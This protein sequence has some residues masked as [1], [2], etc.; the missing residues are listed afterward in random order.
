MLRSRA[1][2]VFAAIFVAV[3]LVGCNAAK[4]PEVNRPETSKAGSPAVEAPEGGNVVAEIGKEKITLDDINEMIRAIPEQYQPVAQANKGLFLDS[5]INQKLFYAEASKLNFDKDPDVQRQ[6]EE[7][8]K[9]IIIK[10]YLRKE[11]EDT[12]RVSDEDAKKY[13]EANK[14]KFKEPE[15]VNISHILVDNEAEAKDILS[16]LKGGADFA[17]LAKEKSKDASK[18]KGGELGLIAKGQTVPEFEQAA[19][20]LQSG[21]ISDVVKTQFGYHIIKVTEK[22]PE[23]MMAYDEIKDQL[24]QMMLSG[25]QKERFD[26]LLKDLKDKNKVVIYKDVL[27]PPQPKVEPKAVEPV[28]PAQAVPAQQGK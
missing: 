24:K 15:K 25:K 18:D 2:S 20:A 5:I 28:N 1:V 12:V 27:T 16:K 7:A 4:K 10:A 13:Y 21:Q 17:A 3:A 23:K 11:I 26:M 19:F 14:D 22:Q 9:E 6:L 8:R